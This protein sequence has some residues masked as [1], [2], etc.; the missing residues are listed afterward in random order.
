MFASH[1][2]PCHVAREVKGTPQP[3]A[4]LA[5]DPRRSE[6]WSRSTEGLLF[7]RLWLFSQGPRRVDAELQLRAL[8]DATTNSTAWLPLRRVA[9]ASYRLVGVFTGGYGWLVWDGQLSR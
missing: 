2:N 6:N 5:Q 9:T 8:L 7:E 4:A 3:S 1:R